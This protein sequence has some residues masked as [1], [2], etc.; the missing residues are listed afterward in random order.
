MFEVKKELLDSHEALLDVTVEE[1]TVQKA[2]RS[3][4]RQIARQINIPGFRKGKAPYSVVVRYVGE[5]SVMQ[6][7]ADDILERQSSPFF[8][9]F[10]S[11]P[12]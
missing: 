11:S 8:I 9:R 2:M 6:E 10:H 12:L 5:G 4:A 3:A 7:A 1:S